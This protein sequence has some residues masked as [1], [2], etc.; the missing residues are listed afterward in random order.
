M[1]FIH[2]SEAEKRVGKLVK[3]AGWIHRKRESGSLIFIVLR[4][5]T[6]TIQV[7]IKKDNVD[8]KAWKA[9]V[10]TT[11]ESSVKLGGVVKEDKRAPTGFEVEAKGFENV[12]IS[13]PF[14]ITEY[15]S[16][17]LLL[18]KRHLWLRS[19]KMI[20]VMR[21]RSYIFRYAREFLDRRGFYEVTPP[22]ITKSGGETGADMFEI[23]FFG[24]KAY[25]TE[26]SQLYAEALEFALE[27]TY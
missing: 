11:V 19:I 21:A 10:D 2:I 23:D 14:P 9:A 18:D 22:I 4:D 6:G 13:E 24:Q 12:N 27:K 25:L 20:N 15:Q 16:T 3:L 7:A 17:E 1:A 26:S 8:E 5:V